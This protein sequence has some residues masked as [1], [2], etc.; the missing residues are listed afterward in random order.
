MSDLNWNLREILYEFK[1]SRLPVFM[2]I[3]LHK[4]IR[5]R[6][7]PSNELIHNETGI[8]SAPISNAI[9]WLVNSQAVML[10]PFERRVGL[11]LKLPNR[12]NIYQLTGVVLIDEEYYPYMN[13]AP[14]GWQSIAADLELMGNSLLSKQLT[15]V[16][17]LFSKRLDS[18]RKGI[19]GNTR[20]DSKKESVRKRSTSPLEMHPLI[21]AWVIARGIDAVNIGAP[22]FTAK[23][24]AC[25]KRMTNWEL[26]PTD[27]EIDAVI[28]A[29][30]ARAYRFDW[31]EADIPKARLTKP[32]PVTPTGPTEREMNMRSPIH[33]TNED[34]ERWQKEQQGE[35]TV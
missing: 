14:E 28:K 30:S 23:D 29:S 35:P 16:N 10:V 20:E 9:D 24:T 32:K 21:A 34:F 33:K 1:D 31:L 22:V 27:T 8:S 11:E 4:N 18:K 25:A 7:W 17:S 2:C 19:K 12:K 3:Y 13:L 6:S 26:P 5:N 15:D